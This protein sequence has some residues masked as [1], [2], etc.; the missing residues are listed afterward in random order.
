MVRMNDRD[1]F[2]RRYW[3]VE[4]LGERGDSCDPTAARERRHMCSVEAG[5]N[6]V[7]S[8]V[9]DFDSRREIHA[10]ALDI[11]LPCRLVPSSTDGHFHL[12]IDKLMPWPDYV[13][14]MRVL[15]DVG[16]LEHGYVDSAI[17]RGQSF[18][19]LPHVRKEARVG[20]DS[21]MYS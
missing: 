6:V 21:Y 15:Q 8:R 18:L 1:D 10:P 13:H 9:T 20:S 3:H 7:G 16:I 17:A 4:A 5:A 11:D 2:G 12:Y 19:R 14:L